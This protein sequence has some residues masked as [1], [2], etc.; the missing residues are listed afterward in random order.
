MKRVASP[1]TGRMDG[2]LQT[3]GRIRAASYVRRGPRLP[4][5]VQRACQARERGINGGCPGGVPKKHA[6]LA[7]RARPAAPDWHRVDV[8]PS[9]THA[10][11]SSRS[12][13]NYVRSEERAL[14][15]SVVAIVEG[16]RRRLC[17]P[18]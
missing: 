9:L 16:R 13:E 15:E 6:S 14:S 5:T 11:P 8:H 1:M 17:R 3:C 10:K 7:R 18:R 2:R 4:D 12:A